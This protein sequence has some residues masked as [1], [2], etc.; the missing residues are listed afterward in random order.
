[1]Q[2]L[3]QYVL[4]KRVRC[5]KTSNSCKKCYWIQLGLEMSVACSSQYVCRWRDCGKWIRSSYCRGEMMTGFLLLDAVC[6][7]Y[8]F[9]YLRSLSYHTRTYTH[10]ATYIPCA[11]ATQFLLTHCNLVSICY[12]LATVGERMR[13][14][15]VLCK[16]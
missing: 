8:Q 2:Y 11:R 6:L 5:K 16:L 1:M 13:A 15:V 3:E 12:A 14:S 7:A 4:S 10:V 9:L